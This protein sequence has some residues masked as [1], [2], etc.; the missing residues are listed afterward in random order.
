MASRAGKWLKKQRTGQRYALVN[1]N[2]TDTASRRTEE[3]KKGTAGEYFLLHVLSSHALPTH[4]HSTESQYTPSI[5]PTASWGRRRQ[6]HFLGPR[7]L[8]QEEGSLL[9]LKVLLNEHNYLNRAAGR[10][11]LVLQEQQPL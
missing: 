5:Q 6:P 4:P 3:S 1:R 2:D 8:Q 10:L 7:I 9:I 11:E